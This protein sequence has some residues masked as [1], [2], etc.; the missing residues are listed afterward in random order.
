[1]QQLKDAKK[2]K[3]EE[4]FGVYNDQYCLYVNNKRISPPST[5]QELSEN[6]KSFL[7]SAF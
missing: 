3:K 2:D 7:R 6:V 5:T 4:R 1:M